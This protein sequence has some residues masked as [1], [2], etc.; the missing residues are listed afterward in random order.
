MGAFSRPRPHVETGKA[1]ASLLQHEV[2]TEQGE[3]LEK[4]VVAVRHHLD[5][6]LGRGSRGVGLHQP[7]V[8]G[9]VVG[10]DVEPAAVVV[11]VVLVV[12][13]AGP[14][15]LERAFGTVGVE[16]PV[17]GG[18]RLRRSDQ[19]VALRPGPAHLAVERLVRLVV[20]E[21]VLGLR[22]AQRVPPDLVPAQRLGMLARAEERSVVVG[23]DEVARHPRQLVVEQGIGGQVLHADGVDAAAFDVDRIGEQ[24]PVGADLES[25]HLAEVAAF[26]QGVDVEQN[27]L[28]VDRRP[29]VDRRRGIEHH[30]RVDRRRRID[31]PPAVDGVLP[32]VLVSG[33]V[34]VLALAVRHRHVGLPD[35][36]LDLGEQGLLQ[37]LGRRHHRL[38]VGVLGLEMGGDGGVAALAQPV[39][40]VDAHHAVRLVADGGDP[41]PRRGNPFGG[42]R[43]RR[44]VRDRRH[45]VFTGGA[46]RVGSGLGSSRI[47]RAISAMA[48]SSWGSP[49]AI[50]DFGSFSTSMSGSTP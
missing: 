2:A 31:R 4:H 34:E 22:C 20:D 7:E 12:A 39:V 8:A 6:P 14:E 17:L 44:G 37:R 50:T 11:D 24:A 33:V 45:G 25:G 19:Q 36:P 43:L 21:D 5:P 40:V 49:P 46:G 16:Q 1:V 48:R 23:P 18:H 10:A 35:A 47:I 38:R 42:Q 26:G 9:A 28:P 41:R 13:R 3:R 29:G 27:L 15:H 30:G 32:P